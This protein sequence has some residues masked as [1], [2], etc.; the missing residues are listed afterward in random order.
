MVKKKQNPENSWNCS[1]DLSKKNKKQKKTT[2][3][4]GVS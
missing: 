1:E 2:N 3:K 4:Q